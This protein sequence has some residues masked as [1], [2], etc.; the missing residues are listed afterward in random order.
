M[1]IKFKNGSKIECYESTS[2]N[3]RG[4]RSKLI[5]FYCVNCNTIHVDYPIKN[6]MIFGEENLTTMCRESF[7]K[8]LELLI[9]SE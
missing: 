9:K 8:I 5:S 4:N 7:E 6:M 2:C 1:K 3:V